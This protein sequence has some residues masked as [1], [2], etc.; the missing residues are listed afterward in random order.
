MTC[1]TCGCELTRLHWKCPCGTV[2]AIPIPPSPEGLLL[3][4]ALEDD[5]QEQ[6]EQLWYVFSLETE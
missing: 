2:Q 3:A 4:M 6:V 5:A 1:E